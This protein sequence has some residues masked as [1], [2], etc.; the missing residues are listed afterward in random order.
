M[1]NLLFSSLITLFYLIKTYS[2]T[3]QT[4]DSSSTATA[5]LSG[6]KTTDSVVGVSQE[7]RKGNCTEA[8]LHPIRSILEYSQDTGNYII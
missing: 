4:S 5:I 2:S 3:L 7:T 6:Q 1:T 8:L